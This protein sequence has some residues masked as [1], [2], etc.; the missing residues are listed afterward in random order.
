MGLGNQ[1]VLQRAMGQAGGLRGAQQ[2]CIER[3]AS[4]QITH[5][6]ANMVYFQNAI[7]S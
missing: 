7:F 4:R 2:A 3:V 1:R 6:D 5:R